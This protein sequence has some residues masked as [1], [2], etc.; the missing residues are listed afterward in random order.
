M[1]ALAKNGGVI[2]I[3]SVASF[4][5]PKKYSDAVQKIRTELQVP[6]RKVIWRMSKE[7]RNLLKPKLDELKKRVEELEKTIPGPTLNTYVDHIEHAIKTAGINHVGIGSDFDGGGKVPGFMNHADS[8][9]ITAEL[10]KRGYNQQ[11]INKIWGGNLMRVWREVE[12][13]GK[14]QAAAPDNN[15]R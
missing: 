14:Q 15:L 3:V 11:D 10:L 12:A 6:A 4:L 8:L 7:E 5:E 1:K 13:V 2:Q 9:N